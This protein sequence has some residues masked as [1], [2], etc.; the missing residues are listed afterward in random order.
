MVICLDLKVYYKFTKYREIKMWEFSYI[1]P[2]VYKLHFFLFYV[3]KVRKFI[4]YADL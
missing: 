2:K 3:Y 4:L 1:M